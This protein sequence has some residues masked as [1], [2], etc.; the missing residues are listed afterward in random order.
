MEPHLKK[1]SFTVATLNARAIFIL[2]LQTLFR[3]GKKLKENFLNHICGFLTVLILYGDDIVTELKQLW[4]D[5]KPKNQ[6]WSFTRTSLGS[7]IKGL[8][9]P[10]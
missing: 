7:T 9:K 6:L 10:I 5:R 1:T 8:T 4:T 2:K 3:S